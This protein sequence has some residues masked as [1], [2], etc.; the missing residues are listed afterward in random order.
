MRIRLL[1]VL[2][3]LFTALTGC[4]SHLRPE[5]SEAEVRLLRTLAGHT[6]WVYATQFS[7]DGRKLLSGS[8]DKTLRLW[9]VETGEELKTFRGHTELIG[10]VA[11]SPDE[12]LV[13]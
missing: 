6:D 12:K 11:F 9:D 4:G 10:S 2:A 1:W 5:G 13:A 8:G 7:P 3:L